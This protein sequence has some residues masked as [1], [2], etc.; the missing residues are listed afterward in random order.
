MQ[1]SFVPAV[2]ELT[3]SDFCS[4]KIKHCTRDSDGAIEDSEE[5]GT[6]RCK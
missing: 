4:A 1:G 6:K 2:D 5:D 3:G